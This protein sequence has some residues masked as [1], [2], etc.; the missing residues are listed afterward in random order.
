MPSVSRSHHWSTL[1]NM[2]PSLLRVHTGITGVGIGL[3]KC[4][5]F[6][7]ATG[8][9]HTR[10]ESVFVFAA[11]LAAI[12]MLSNHEVLARGAEAGT[13]VEDSMAAAPVG[14]RRRQL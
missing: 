10:N 14:I 11:L 12:T 2:L 1:N 8:E 7:D 6:I 5:P 9:N 4:H 13:T 3:L